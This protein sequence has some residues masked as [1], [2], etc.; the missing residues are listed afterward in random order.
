MRE[1]S[2]ET[3]SP[4]FVQWV[5]K[6]L[7]IAVEQIGVSAEC[8]APDVRS[9]AGHDV[10]DAVVAQP[11]AVGG[12]GFVIL[13][14]VAVEPFQSVPCGQPDVPPA[15]LQNTLYV[16]LRQ[17]LFQRVVPHA[18]AVLSVCGR[19]C[20]EGKKQKKFSERHFTV[21]FSGGKLLTLVYS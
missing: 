1:D 11:H 12:I 2:P 8:L 16:V 4:L 19:Q 20:E 9:V 7:G 14:I 10:G 5:E 3:K 13:E 18:E 17:P 6:L 15:V 21:W